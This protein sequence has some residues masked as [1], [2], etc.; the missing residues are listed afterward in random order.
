MATVL[1]PSDFASV[2]KLSTEARADLLEFFGST[3]VQPTEI[4]ALIQ[5]MRTL[6]PEHAMRKDKQGVY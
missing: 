6:K 1:D 5:R 3:D 2:M 4:T